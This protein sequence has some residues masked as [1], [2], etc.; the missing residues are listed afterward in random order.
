MNITI[1][2][3][4]LTVLTGL[5]DGATYFIQAFFKT[6]NNKFIACD[7]ALLQGETEPTEDTLGLKNNYFKIT[8]KTGVNIYLKSLNKNT[9]VVV[10]EC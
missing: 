1:N 8:K 4:E 5:T 3:D 9:T 7:V 10:E 6:F 2:N